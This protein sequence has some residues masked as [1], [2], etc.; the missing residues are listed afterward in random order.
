VDDVGE[1]EGGVPSRLIEDRPPEGGKG[2]H[3]MTNVVTLSGAG[4][5]EEMLDSLDALAREGARRMIAAALRAEADEYVE[6]HVEEVDEDGHR[7][8]VR[9]G[10]A[11]QRKVT[12]G[13]GTIPIKAPRVND[14]RIDEETGERKRFS[15]RILPAYARRSPKVG[16]VIPI[17]YLRGL[18]TG[19]FK[20][21]LEQLLGEDAAGLS[22]TTIARMCKEW[23]EHHDRFS[24]R[25]LG[26]TRYA[27]LFMDGIHVSVRLGEDPKVC[28]LI[29]IGVREDGEKELL[30]V[31]DGYRESTESWAGVFRDMKRRGLNEPRLVVGDGA[32]GAW[33]A[34]RDVYPGAGEQRCW[35][36]ASGNIIDCLPKRLHSRAK[37]LLSEIIE[38]PTRKD[39]RLA[40]EVFRE[41]Y[42][43]KY[44]KALAKLD[45]DWTALTAFYDY[46]AEHW[47]H[48]RT[49]NPI[50]SAFATVRLRT[51]VTKG[52]GSKTA[53]LA[54]AYKL[55]AT[56]QER[57]RR[58]NGH[59]LV[60][61]VLDGAVFKDGIRVTDDDNHDD[62]TTDEK[63]AA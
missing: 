37:G 14:K 9:N 50:E 42:G 23:E 13:S 33:A 28:L 17:L 30:A 6:R 54:M 8:V 56:A 62:G 27:Y 45:R 44:P 5:N 53:A 63:V 57:W 24:K 21:A 20:P 40:L 41:E 1:E 43:S 59:H 35:F 26:F 34:L 4:G 2:R 38:A 60:A 15:S 18:S 7:L 61:D 25:H 19:D 32:L 36:H 12:V 51:R 11:K 31:E 46:P 55:L 47:R 3:A 52:A 48:L 39:A 22:P 58:F 16:E 49:T 29:V 10:R